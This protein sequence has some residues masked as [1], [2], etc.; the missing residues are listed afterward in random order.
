MNAAVIIG[1]GPAGCQCA[2][3][4]SMLGYKAIIVEQSDRLGG[5]QASSPY[6]NN[7]M[8]GVMHLTGREYA[9]H[10][11]QHI[12]WMNIPVFFNQTPTHI[13]SLSTGFTVQLSDKVIDA[14]NVVIATGVKPCRDYFSES[15]DTIIGPGQ[16]IFDFDFAN[17]RVA[18]L[19]GGDNAA[20]NYDLIQQQK[21]T[22]CHVYTR[23][24]RAR[25]SLWGLVHPEDVYLFPY[26]VDQAA[27]TITHQ[28]ETR[29]YDVIIV[30]YG[31]EA[32]F[33]SCLLSLESVLRDDRGFI[34]TDMYCRT[35]VAGI[36]AIGEVANRMH[37]CVTTAM[38]DGVVAA[39]AIQ[40]DMDK[41]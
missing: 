28:G 16:R 23:T 1:G 11:Q 9:K 31:W 27:K 7:W 13:Q 4:L 36:Y 21:P 25:K 32:N 33:P 22:A 2:L 10:I 30:L 8:L 15:A 26:D 24:I 14:Y 20:E 37:P 34:A 12:E 19:G 17:K 35:P 39:K 40:E 29:R 18:I 6:Q 41:K 3:W 5:L 38:A